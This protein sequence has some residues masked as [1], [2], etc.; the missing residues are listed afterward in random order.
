[1][2]NTE[3]GS[4]LSAGLNLYPGVLDQKKRRKKKVN[5]PLVQKIWFEPFYMSMSAVEDRVGAT[6]CIKMPALMG[7]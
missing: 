7:H 1:M 2:L 4:V 6:Q 3:T 5:R